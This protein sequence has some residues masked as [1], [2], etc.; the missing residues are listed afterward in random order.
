MKLDALPD[1]VKRLNPQLFQ[2]AKAA[3]VEEPDAYACTGLERDLL[4]LCSHELTRRGIS[5]LHLSPRARE[6]CGWPDLI[7][8]NAGSPW[9]IELKTATGRLSKEQIEMQ[10]RMEMNGWNVATIRSHEAFMATVFEGVK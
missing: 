8:V 6:A 3:P 7:F 9:G 4:K 5:F 10:K 2:E 1:E